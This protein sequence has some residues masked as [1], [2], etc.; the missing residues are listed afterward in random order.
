MVNPSASL[1]FGVSSL[2]FT[3]LFEGQTQDYFGNVISAVHNS[4]HKDSQMHFPPRTDV[5]CFCTCVVVGN[6]SK[7][8]STAVLP[9]QSIMG[10]GENAGSLILSS[11]PLLMK[12][13]HVLCVLRSCRLSSTSHKTSNKASQQKESFCPWHHILDT[14]WTQKSDQNSPHSGRGLIRHPVGWNL[15]AFWCC[16]ELASPNKCNTTGV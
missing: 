16:S 4:V 9:S 15:T 13:S 12:R 11:T 2:L 6:A 14:I 5:C 7:A 8:H 10:Q 1:T 3:L